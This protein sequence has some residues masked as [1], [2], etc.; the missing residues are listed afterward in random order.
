MSYDTHQTAR[1]DLLMF[2]LLPQLGIAASFA[3]V[4][5]AGKPDAEPVAG[6]DCG[7]RPEDA[8]DVHLFQLHFEKRGVLSVFG[9]A[10]RTCAQAERIAAA[11]LLRLVRLQFDAV[12][13]SAVGRLFVGDA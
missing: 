13:I 3:A 4:F 6:P 8:R 12:H 5:A 2:P 10:V 11:Q 7:D 1:G 9:L